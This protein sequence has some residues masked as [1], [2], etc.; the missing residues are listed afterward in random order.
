M[1]GPVSGERTKGGPPEGG[2]YDPASVG[3]YLHVPF[4]ASICGYCDFYR[5]ASA[6]GVP[7]G[8]EDL[9]L[10]EAERYRRT[11]PL[12]V[13]TVFFGGGTPSL[14]APERLARLLGGLRALFRFSPGAEVTLEANPETVTAERLEGWRA[15][16][17]TRLSIGVQSLDE[18]VLAALERRASSEVALRAVALAAEAGFAHLSADVMSAVPGQDGT[19]LERTVETL[20]GTGLDHLSLY[21]L[22]LHRGT[23]LWESVLAGERSLPDDEAA[24]DLYLAVHAQMASAGFEHYE[25][26]NYARPGGRCRHN[27]RYWLGGETIG[28]GPS[29]WTRFE[30]RLCGNPRSLE[31]WTGRVLRDEPAH[32]TSEVLT[33]DRKREDTLI[34]GLRVLEG[35]DV[36]KVRPLLSAGGRDPQE[37]IRPLVDHGYGVLEE[38]R[39]RLT[40]VGFLTSNEILA[41]LLPGRWPRPE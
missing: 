6:D 28:L 34:F 35:V 30:D 12:G 14:L 27:L 7:A 22:D 40:P 13:D 38:G 39:L 4:C 9:L 41:F 11:P 24:A 20:A 19:S 23:R 8:F 18:D 33:E 37:L 1:D 15:A 5:M 10:R 25:V 17:V 31:A 21:S 29:A 16:G 2:W 3:L 36:E 26:S 32:L